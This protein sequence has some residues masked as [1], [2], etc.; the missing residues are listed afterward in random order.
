MS[1]PSETHT[2]VLTIRLDTT[3]TKSDT[4]VDNL[5]I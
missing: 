3:N 5:Y 4:L 1:D 2:G